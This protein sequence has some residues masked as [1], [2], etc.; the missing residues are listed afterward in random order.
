MSAKKDD[1]RT[2][3][4]PASVPQPALAT[5][6]TRKLRSNTSGRA[7]ATL[8]LDAEQQE[9]RGEACELSHGEVPL[10]EHAGSPHSPAQ[11]RGGHSHAHLS[12]K[13]PLTLT[14]YHTDRRVRA[15]AS[16]VNSREPTL[17]GGLPDSNTDACT[18]HALMESMNARNS[19]D[20]SRD[21]PPHRERS[22]P[23][24]PHQ[25]GVAPHTSR[26]G[27]SPDTPGPLVE[28]GDVRWSVDVALPRAQFRKALQSAKLSPDT[29]SDV[30]RERRRVLSC[31]Y[32]KRSRVKTVQRANEAEGAYT[33]LCTFVEGIRSVAG[34]HFDGAPDEVKHEFEAGLD[35]LVAETFGIEP[36]QS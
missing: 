35:V 5:H 36:S 29:L 18:A 17:H 32:A 26:R 31:E 7:R 14:P 8:P 27:S 11:P 9:A 3:E 2:Q 12:T 21:T 13:R 30:Q 23:G 19:N 4:E 22:G 16:S 10:H 20:V 34:N 25:T 24:D 15:R 33:T 28:T 1:P 6:R